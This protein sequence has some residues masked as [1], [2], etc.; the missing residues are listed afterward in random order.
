MNKAIKIIIFLLL[1]LLFVLISFYQNQQQQQLPPPSPPSSQQSINA[2]I[3]QPS[4]NAKS[5][6][7]NGQSPARVIL[8]CH[9]NSHPF[10][11]RTILLEPRQEIKV[12]RSVPRSRVEESNAI[13]D[14]K[15]LSRN[16]AIIWYV[17]GKF[18]IKVSRRKC[19]ERPNTAPYIQ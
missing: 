7:S 11:K 18:F 9:S 1:L 8:I 19:N 12:G 2:S 6:N 5:V 16:H 15:V 13:F 10:Q 17:D 14:C 3:M 4:A